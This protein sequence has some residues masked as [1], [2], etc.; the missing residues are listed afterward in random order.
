MRILVGNE[1]RFYREVI[2]A[3]LQEL[4][5]HLE[6]VIV[7]PEDLDGAV[8]QRRPQLVLCSRLG[9]VVETRCLAWVLLY[10]HGEASVV[11]SVAGHRQTVPD[12]G[13]DGLLRVVDQTALLARD[14]AP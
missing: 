13:L 7:E 6:V 1:P 9:E 11:I 3:T 2:A 14:D 10:P 4:R 8:V 12:P 5:P